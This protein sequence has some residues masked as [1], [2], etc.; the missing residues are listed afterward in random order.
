MLYG[1]TFCE[2]QSVIA[3]YC[4]VDYSKCESETPRSARFFIFEFH[5]K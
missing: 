3:K 1:Q 2:F 4:I 5:H